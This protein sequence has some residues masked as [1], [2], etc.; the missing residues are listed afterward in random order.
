MQLRV[1]SSR[2]WASAADGELPSAACAGAKTEYSA[3]VRI[4][5]AIR[6]ATLA[7]RR[8]CLDLRRAR[9]RTAGVPVADPASAWRAAGRGVGGGTGSLAGQGG[10]GGKARPPDRGT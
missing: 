3:P 8:R 5:P 4:S 9:A 10:R 6:P 7:T 1:Y 2:P